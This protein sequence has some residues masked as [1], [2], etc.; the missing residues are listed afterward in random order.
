MADDA[1]PVTGDKEKEPE[2]TKADRDALQAVVDKERKAA[3]DAAAA[4]KAKDDELAKLKNAQDASKSDMER[5]H[6]QIKAL[7]ERAEKAERD[8]LVA[9][10][11]QAKKL[12]AALASRLAG[13]T[14]EELEADA[15]GL[16]AA[17]NI[18]TDA[19]KA[20]GVK[21]PVAKPSPALRA[22]GGLDPETEP[23]ETDPLKLAAKIPRF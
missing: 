22:S 2:F 13:T 3:R 9:T 8:A 19:D 5:V 11:A 4:L 12:P 10:V 1:T 23:D 16:I 17:L 21:P 15:D 14:K 6:E 20:D 18:S 7:T